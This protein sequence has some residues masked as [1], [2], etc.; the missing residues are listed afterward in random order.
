MIF[1]Y[2]PFAGHKAY[3]PYLSKSENRKV[4]VLVPNGDN[5]LARK[6][7]IS[8]ARFIYSCSIGKPVED[9]FEVDHIDGS[10]LNDD[11]SNLQLLSKNDNIRK[12]HPGSSSIVELE[13][14]IC[15]ESFLIRR[16]NTHLIPSRKGNSTCCSKA[17]ANK[18]TSQTL[19]AR[20]K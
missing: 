7:S 3:G 11:I 20:S 17:C 16:G 15:K 13:C 18:K 5:G 8:Y 1:E 6:T 12:S 9:R 10:K 19:K 14:P 2:H 4:V